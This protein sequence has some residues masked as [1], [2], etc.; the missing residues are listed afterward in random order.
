MLIGSAQQLE[1]KSEIRVA[2]PALP[3]DRPPVLAVRGLSMVFASGLRAVDGVDLEVRP[4]ETLGI[5]GESGSGKT[6]LGRCLLRIHEPTA[7]TIAYRSA[8]G[9]EIDV[10]TADRGTL[11][12]VRREMRMIFQDP[13]ASLNPRKTVAN[14]IGEPLRLAGVRSRERDAAGG[15]AHGASSG[16]SPP[17]ANATRT[18]SPAASASASASPAPSR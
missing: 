12:D 7:G 1:H 17:G 11:R 14:I 3:A 18:P 5:V 4:G 9:R 10:R 6:T 8:D 15:R 16:S 13:V 2:R